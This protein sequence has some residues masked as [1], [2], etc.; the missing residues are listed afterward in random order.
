MHLQ[1]YVRRASIE[2]VDV[3]GADP[4][5]VNEFPVQADGR[6]LRPCSQQIATRSWHDM[7]YKIELQATRMHRKHSVEIEHQET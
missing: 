4:R 1:V 6:A 7:N 5:P 3:L 2:S